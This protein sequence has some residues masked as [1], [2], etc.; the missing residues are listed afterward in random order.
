[1]RAT[2]SH[3]HLFR[4]NTVD[5]RVGSRLCKTRFWLEGQRRI[6]KADFIFGSLPSTRQPQSSAFLDI[7]GQNIHFE[8]P[9]VNF[10]C[11]PMNRH[12]QGL[13]ACLKR[14]N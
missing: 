2:T 6:G 8:L 3:L 4:I 10:R 11:A 13:S 5:V 12:P 14:A 9:P 1:M 7:L